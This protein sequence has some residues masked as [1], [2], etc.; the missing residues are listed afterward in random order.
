MSTS[1]I[2]EGKTIGFKTMLD[3]QGFI[4][5]RRRINAHDICPICK[6]PFT[7]EGTTSVLLI[8]SNQADVPN[9]FCHTECTIDKTLEYVFKIIADSY[10]EAK[11]HI[12]W[13]KENGWHMSAEI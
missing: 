5:A 10:E 6:K 12:N 7:P 1:I 9:R 2:Y 11:Q 4:G 13:M 8:I 3:G